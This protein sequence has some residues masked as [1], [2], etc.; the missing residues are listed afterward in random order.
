MDPS[1]IK[2][3]YG[4]KSLQSAEKRERTSF[5][6]LK[7]IK[8]KITFED[9]ASM[10][11]IITQIVTSLHAESPIASAL[12]AGHEFIDTNDNETTFSSL[13]K[14]GKIAD[15]RSKSFVEQPPGKAEPKV[16]YL[17]DDSSS[18]EEL[19]WW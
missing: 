1:S 5:S 16:H 10:R 9:K 8:E 17:E 7:L 11:H 14:E 13:M 15:I 19:G 12:F 3:G 18:G 4:P 6:F 2:T